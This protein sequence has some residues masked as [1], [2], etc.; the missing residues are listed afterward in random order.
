MLQAY[1][2]SPGLVFPFHF[3]NPGG[4][5]SNITFWLRALE[6]YKKGLVCYFPDTIIRLHVNKLRLAVKIHK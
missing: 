6:D 4:Y 5:V 1:Y 2:G 3:L